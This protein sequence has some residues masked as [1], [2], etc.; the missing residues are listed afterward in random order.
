MNLQHLSV[1]DCKGAWEG[2]YVYNTNQQPCTSKWYQGPLLE[3]SE[4]NITNPTIAGYTNSTTS[5]APA[6]L[7]PRQRKTQKIFSAPIKHSNRGGSQKYTPISKA[8]IFEG[9]DPSIITRMGI[10]TKGSSGARRAL[11]IKLKEA[12][13]HD[14]DVIQQEE[15]SYF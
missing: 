2:S 4:N 15:V 3:F 10:D 1:Y 12:V 11:L 13:M 14:L 8:D 5:K 6:D 9:I 7:T